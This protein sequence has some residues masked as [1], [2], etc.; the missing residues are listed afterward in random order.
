MFYESKLVILFKEHERI[1]FRLQIQ[2]I[3]FG[4]VEIIVSPN[5]GSCL[6]N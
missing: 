1:Y 6:H 5:M 3:V 4:S 2:I